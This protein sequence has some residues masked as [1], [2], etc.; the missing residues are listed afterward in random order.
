MLVSIII[1]TFNSEK[2]LKETLDCAINQSYLFKE[3]IIVDDGSID[4]TRLILKDYSDKYNF[5]RVYH[6]VNKGA[7]NARN[8]G[9]E[10]SKGELINFLDADDLMDYNKIEKQVAII[11]NS[12]DS[13]IGCNWIRFNTT[14]PSFTGTY[15]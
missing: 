8:F 7:C 12:Q 10:V 15:K 6:Q 2:F 13:I 5:L 11:K 3:I 1:P 9:F 4:K 14:F